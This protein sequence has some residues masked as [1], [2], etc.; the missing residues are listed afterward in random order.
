[1]DTQSADDIISPKLAEVV[2]LGNELPPIQRADSV[3]ASV[4]L[5]VM[6]NAVAAV[7][8]SGRSLSETF[9]PFSLQ[10]TKPRMFTPQA[11]AKKIPT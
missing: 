7:H 1:V 8:A 2:A 5:Q 9:R 4:E 10:R 6:T 11:T 3:N